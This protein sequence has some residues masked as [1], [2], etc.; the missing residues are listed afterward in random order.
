MAKRISSKLCQAKANGKNCDKDARAKCFH[1]SCDLCVKHFTEHT[2]F[3]ENQMILNEFDQ[4]LSTLSISSRIL[5]NPFVELEKWRLNAHKKLDQL[6]EEKRQEI[7]IKIAEYR[8]IFTKQI[9]EQRSQIEILQQRFN[10]FSRQIHLS[11]KDLNDLEN[12][13]ISTRQF[14]HN[15]DK[16]SIKLNSPGEF[17]VQ[18]QT[19]FFDLQPSL[20]RHSRSERKESPPIRNEIKRRSIKKRSASVC[21]L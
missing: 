12:Q 9:C 5:E 18:I 19:D 21:V 8:T 3:V 17:S 2:Q 15:I 14:F 16:H 1:C 7:Q 11:T 13:I 10:D 4:K 20:G 6:A